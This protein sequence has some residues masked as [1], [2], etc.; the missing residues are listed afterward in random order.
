MRL[1]LGGAVCLLAGASGA[2]TMTYFWT[3]STDNG[4]TDLQP[5]EQASLSLWAHMDPEATGL[6]GTIYDI[7]GIQHWDTG[8]LVWY[9]NMFDSFGEQADG[10]NNI[11]AIEAFQLPPMFNPN[12]SADNPIEM[13][14]LW[15]TTDD[16]TPRVIEVGD[17]NHLNND[18]YTDEFGTSV[19]YEGVPGVA[20]FTVNIPEPWAL[21]LLGLAAVRR[22][23]R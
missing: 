8:D 3:V 6:A 18:V 20:R 5:G 14:R 2:Q 15:W 17:M 9:Y 7:R 12:F 10:E 11:W 16:Y 22:V 13:Y 21:T 4:D 23:R 19:P 1:A